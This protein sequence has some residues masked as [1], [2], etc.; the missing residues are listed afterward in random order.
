LFDVTPG[1][2]GFLSV[3]RSFSQSAPIWPESSVGGGP[4]DALAQTAQHS[5]VRPASI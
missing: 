2:L 4:E 1:H 5:V 3:M